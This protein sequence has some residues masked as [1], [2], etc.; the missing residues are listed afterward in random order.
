[1]RNVTLNN[2]YRNRVRGQFLTRG[3]YM[4]KI[5][6]N[7]MHLSFVRRDKFAALHTLP[8]SSRGSRSRPGPAHD[9]RRSRTTGVSSTTP[10]TSAFWWPIARAKKHRGLGDERRYDVYNLDR[11]RT[12]YGLSKNT[13][14]YAQFVP[15]GHAIAEYESH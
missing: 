11:R 9:A 4:R 7:K 14:T 13:R 2:D 12:N 8:P 15:S 3:F 5:K 6:I 10:Y 1:M